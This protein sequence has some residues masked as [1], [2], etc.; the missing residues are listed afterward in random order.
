MPFPPCPSTEEAERRP[1]PEDAPEEGELPME[2]EVPAEEREEPDEEEV[3]GAWSFVPRQQNGDDPEEHLTLWTRIPMDVEE[4]ENWQVGPRSPPSAVDSDRQVS[5]GE[6]E[7]EREKY[8]QDQIKKYEEARKRSKRTCCLGNIFRRCQGRPFCTKNA[9]EG[10]AAPIPPLMS[11]PIGQRLAAL[12]GQQE[13]A[14]ESMPMAELPARAEER[15][16]EAAEEVRDEPAPRP[17]GRFSGP[18]H[19]EIRRLQRRL[20]AS[21][22]QREELEEDYDL[23]GERLERAEGEVERLQ[24]RWRRAEECARQAEDEGRRERERYREEI[25]RAEQAELRLL[26]RIERLTERGERKSGGGEGK[27]R[28]Q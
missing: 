21:E 8:C 22:R 16:R 12:A 23:L 19:T 1:L 15:R 17:P 4:F 25:Q 9:P 20:G 14:V 5:G 3:L 11:L 27:R 13:E 7:R 18:A 10:G 26:R 2:V 28:R 24:E 6:R